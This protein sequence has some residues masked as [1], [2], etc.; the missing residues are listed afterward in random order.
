[1]TSTLGLLQTS[2]ATLAPRKNIIA[3]PA[4][5][6]QRMTWTFILIVPANVASLALAIEFRLEADQTLVSVLANSSLL[7]FHFPSLL[8]TY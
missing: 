8:F 5:R 7:R 1:M 3:L 4:K 6:G 2:L